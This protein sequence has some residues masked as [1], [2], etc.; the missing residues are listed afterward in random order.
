MTLNLIILLCAVVLILCV[1]SSKLSNKLGIPTLLLFLALGMLFG[2]DGIVG[3]SFDRY[4]YTEKLCSAALVFIMFYGGFGTNW[5]V[6][7]PV[8]PQA[9]ALSTAGV[10]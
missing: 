1:F 9:I 4:D 3:I 6:G 7:K 5:K 2:S 8:A 10:F